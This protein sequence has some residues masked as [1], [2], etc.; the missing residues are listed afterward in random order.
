MRIWIAI[1]AV[2]AGLAFV[3][4]P[5]AHAFA[6]WDDHATHTQ[7]DQDPEKATPALAAVCCPVPNLP[8]A[9]IVAPYV[10]TASISWNLPA[11]TWYNGRSLAPEPPPPRP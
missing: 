1:V 6:T 7:P 10:S 11:D 3:A 5:I 9:G 8:T 2:V 4:M